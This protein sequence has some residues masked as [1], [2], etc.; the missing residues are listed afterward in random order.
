MAPAPYV[1]SCSP[2]P[3]RSFAKKYNLPARY[4]LYLGGFD[5]RKN[6]NALIQAFHKARPHLPPDAS[7]VL[8]GI[9]PD[10]QTAVLSDPHL[11]IEQLQLA[12]HVH[13]PGWIAAEDV[14]ALYRA[15]A[16]F[17]YPSRYEGFGLPVL[18]AMACGTAVITANAASL[19]EIA[20]EAAVLVDPDDVA[21]L[22]KAI[23]NLCTDQEANGRLT[24]LGLKQVKQFSW[25]KTAAQTL[26]A[27]Q[28]LLN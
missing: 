24:Q 7:L 14:P 8:A 19:P 6:V 5:K 4:I 28:E 21:S 18:E 23:I 26:T 13:C 2:L 11:L 10:K 9:V 16:V 20:G 27:Y 15:A 25:H 22:A 17:V 12:D 1:D 3:D